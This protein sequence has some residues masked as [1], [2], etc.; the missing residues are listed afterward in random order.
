[1]FHPALLL[2]HLENLTK[3]LQIFSCRIPCQP[4]G[5]LQ[6]PFKCRDEL[7]VQFGERDVLLIVNIPYDC[8]HQSAAPVVTCQGSRMHIPG[9]SRPSV[10]TFL[11]GLQNQMP[12]FLGIQNIQ[13]FLRSQSFPII[14]GIPVDDIY[15]VSQCLKVHVQFLRTS[16]FSF[17]THP[18]IVP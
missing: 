8:L 14:H 1:M 6:I 11:H 10:Y 4:A 3:T 15:S 2:S 12:S 17:A 13:N 5:S 7:P 9:R 18:C 16:V